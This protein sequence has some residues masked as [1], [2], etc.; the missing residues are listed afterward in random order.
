MGTLFVV[1][2]PIGNLGDI[3]LRALEV[4]RAVTQIVAEDTRR[5]GLLL[6]RF[7]IHKPLISLFEHNEALRVDWVL[8]ALESGDVALISEAGMPGL[9]DPGYDLIRAAIDRGFRVTPIPGPT[10]ATAALV[11]SG[12]PTDSFVFLGFL[13]RRSSERRSLLESVAYLPRTLVAYEAPHRLAESLADVEA[14]LGDR[15]IVVARELTKV[16]EEI[17]RG[18]VSAARAHFADGVLGEITLV[19]AGS[20]PEPAWDESAVREALHQ[21]MVEGAGTG[22]ATREVTKLSHWPRREVHRLALEIARGLRTADARS[23]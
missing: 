12:L 8:A 13:P 18:L 15:Q 21:A 17:W 11:V 4:L 5:A 23:E 19:I 14:V 2:T 22:A 3:S 7:E 20:P 16:H 6:K 9:S 10:A 1:G